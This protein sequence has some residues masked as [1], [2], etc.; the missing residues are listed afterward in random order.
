[1]IHI[2]KLIYYLPAIEI[3][4]IF[5]AKLRRGVLKR[6]FQDIDFSFL[7]WLLVNC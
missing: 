1:M 5:I 4:Q 3:D 7:H 2:L 6:L